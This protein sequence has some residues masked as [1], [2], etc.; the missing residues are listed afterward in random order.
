MLK[1]NLYCA[2]LVGLDQRQFKTDLTENSQET[3]FGARK[4]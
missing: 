3:V 1:D 2:S 4:H